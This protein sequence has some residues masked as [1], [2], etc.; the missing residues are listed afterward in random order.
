[1]TTHSSGMAKWNTALPDLQN[2]KFPTPSSL[3]FSDEIC[4][5][6]AG[7][8]ILP[9]RK[10][11]STRVLAGLNPCLF[12]FSSNLDCGIAGKP[13]LTKHCLSGLN[14]QFNAIDH[15]SQMAS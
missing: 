5:N 8:V 4:N 15:L 9:S 6:T 13:T 1:M 2:T 12:N 14:P 10:S 7:Y 11:T 3:H